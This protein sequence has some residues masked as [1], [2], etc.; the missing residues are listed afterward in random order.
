[1]QNAA[2]DAFTRL[3]ARNLSRISKENLSERSQYGSRSLHMRC[4]LAVF[5]G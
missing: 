5:S 2:Y 3:F 1:M 4:L